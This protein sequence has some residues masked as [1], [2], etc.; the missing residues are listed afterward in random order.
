[1]EPVDTKDPAYLLELK[2]K[3]TEKHKYCKVSLN[4]IDKVEEHKWYL[5]KNDYPFTFIKGSR[6]KLHRYIW[7]L[8]TGKYYNDNY[9]VDHVN[10]DRLDARDSNLRLVTPAQN[11]YNKTPK[12]E[13]THHITMNSKG[14]VVKITKDKQVHMIDNIKTYEDAKSIYNMMA[15]ELFGEYAILYK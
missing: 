10:R 15:T 12:D 14:Y 9:Y 2:G 1:M 13:L 11:S 8:N 7:F 3:N 4:K 5:D 6:V